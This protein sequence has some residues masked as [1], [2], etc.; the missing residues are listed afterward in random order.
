MVIGENKAV[1]IVL[2]SD[3]TFIDSETNE[4]NGTIYLQRGAS[5]TI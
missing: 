4:N 1:E 2:S 3:S 5:L